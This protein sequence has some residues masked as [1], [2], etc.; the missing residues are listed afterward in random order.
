M[1]HRIDLTFPYVLNQ[2]FYNVTDPSHQANLYDEPFHS[3]PDLTG[4]LSMSATLELTVMY[5]PGTFGAQWVPL[6]T[7][8]WS[9]NI[10]FHNALAATNSP[11]NPTWTPE[12]T[13]PLWYDAF[14][15]FEEEP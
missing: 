1:T 12:S 4:P 11:S 10:D 6:K 5:E 9:L 8:T 14:R 2:A 13:H 3:N 15:P 7:T